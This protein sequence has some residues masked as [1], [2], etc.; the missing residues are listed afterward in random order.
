M[1]TCIKSTLGLTVHFSLIFTH[2]V[3]CLL[4]DLF[5]SFFLP[6]HQPSLII[7]TLRVSMSLSICKL[8]NDTSFDCLF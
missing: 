6:L 3:Y 7:H 5:I 4:W 8:L 1:N 2:Y